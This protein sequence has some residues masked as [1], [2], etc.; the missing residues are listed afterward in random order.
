[1]GLDL[2]TLLASLLGF[3]AIVSVLVNV[4]KKFGVVQDGTSDKWIA[5]F[6]LVGYLILFVVTT[7]FPQ[8]NIPAIDAQLGAVAVVL[9]VVLGYVTTILGS[10]LTYVATKGLPLIGKTFSAKPQ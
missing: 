3:G 6:N 9:N 2:V 5:G 8:I 1:M 4:L 7:W 10:K